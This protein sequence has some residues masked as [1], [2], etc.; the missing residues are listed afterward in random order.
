MAR[1][2]IFRIPRPKVKPSSPPPISPLE[3][4]NQKLTITFR[5]SPQTFFHFM[6]LRTGTS[7]ITLTMLINKTSGLYGLLAL[8]TGFS[9]SPLQLSM[10]IYSLLAL[11]ATALLAPHIK[12]GSPMQCLALAWLYALDSIVNAAY[13]AAFSLAWFALVAK[14]TAPNAD[15]N[16]SSEGAKLPGEKTMND[17]AGFTSPKHD[18]VSAVDVVDGSL[19]VAHTAT[20]ADAATT[21]GALHA[22]LFQ[23]GSIASVIVIAGLWALRIYFILVVTAYARGVLRQHIVATSQTPGAAFTFQTGNSGDKDAEDPFAE[24]KE[25]GQGWRGKLGRVMVKFGRGYWLGADEEGEW[26]RSL[27]GRLRRGKK[28]PQQGVAPPPPGVFERERRR[29]AGTGPPK[30]DTTP[31][32]VE[33][34][35]V[36]PS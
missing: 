32:H 5:P 28:L 2:S 33:L 19:L 7:L 24:G 12:R 8:L 9:L 27:D 3:K 16:G 35:S 23:S 22:A 17:T 36:K 1:P 10:Y 25:A 15:N 14:K 30:L 4:A 18:N 11:A 29:R 6:S 13:T 20:A 31:G 26:A 21:Q 34:G